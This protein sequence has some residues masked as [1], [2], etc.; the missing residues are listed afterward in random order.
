VAIRREEQDDPGFPSV[1]ENVITVVFST[2]HQCKN[3]MLTMSVV[4]QV[5]CTDFH[6]AED[7]SVSQHR[8]KLKGGAYRELDLGRGL[9]WPGN[10][11]G[12][13][14]DRTKNVP[15]LNPIIPLNSAVMEAYWLIFS[16]PFGAI[17]LNENIESDRH[18][19]ET[20]SDILSLDTCE[21]IMTPL[22]GQI[23]RGLR[24]RDDNRKI[25][26]GRL[27]I[28][29]SFGFR[30]HLLLHACVSTKYDHARA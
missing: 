25:V 1:G 26:A 18:S 22:K 4:N 30:R 29:E 9:G 23:L 2:C 24:T 10:H 16:S 5:S 20:S 11:E 17:K 27:R 3:A 14:P 13:K 19:L 28:P 15:Q 7:F 12:D 6:S 21:M 8:R